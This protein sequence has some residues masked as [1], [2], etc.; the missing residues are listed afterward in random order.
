MS[1]GCEFRKDCGFF[2]KFS[3]RRSN[4]WRGLI[5]FY[6]LGKGFRICERRKQYLNQEAV[7]S[8][9]IMPSGKEVSKAFLSLD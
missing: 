2:R 7:G 6:C 5:G 1:E 9:D 8:D 4:L 3:E